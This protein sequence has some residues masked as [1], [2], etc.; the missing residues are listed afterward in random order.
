MYRALAEHQ[1]E[2][3]L[4]SLAENVRWTIIGTTEFSRT[5]EGKTAL[6][7]G[8]LEPFMAKMDG[9]AVI[10]PTNLIAEGDFVAMESR[11]R[12]RTVYAKDYNNTYCHIFRIRDAKVVEVTEYLDTE[13]VTEAFS[14]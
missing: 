2:G 1:P 12:A 7:K 11:G 9:P 3:F 13:L 10:E 14:P 5:Y 6:I 4:D 8:L